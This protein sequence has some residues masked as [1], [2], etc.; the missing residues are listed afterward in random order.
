MA[1][2]LCLIL[3]PLFFATPFL[4]GSMGGGL[5]PGMLFAA[6]AFLLLAGGIVV[7][8]MN[9]ARGWEEERLDE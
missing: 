7:G 1:A 3:L 2:V 6:A 4:L 5:S 9:L 8:A